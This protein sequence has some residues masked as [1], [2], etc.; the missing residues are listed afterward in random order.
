MLIINDP[1]TASFR[2]ILDEFFAV[3]KI[4][5]INHSILIGSLYKCVDSGFSGIFWELLSS[6]YFLEW[7]ETEK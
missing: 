3:N 1:S 2:I 6:S 4:I 5:K 7:E